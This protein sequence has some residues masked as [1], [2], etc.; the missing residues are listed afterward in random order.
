LLRRYAHG[1]GVD[2][3]IVWYEGAGLSVRNYLIADHLGS[4]IAANGA[5]TTRYAYGPYG[6][7]DAWTGSRFRYTGQAALPEVQ[8][9]HYKAR[10]YDP[11]L[12]RFLQTDPVGYE[13]DLNL[14]AYVRNDPLSLSDPSG[15]G[16]ASV[17]VE[18]EAIQGAY[19]GGQGAGVRV[20]VYDDPDERPTIEFGA[21]K[22]GRYGVGVDRGATVGGQYTGG[23]SDDCFGNSVNSRSRRKDQECVAR[24]SDKLAGSK[25]SWQLKCGRARELD[26][27]RHGNFWEQRTWGP[28]VLGVFCAA[29]VLLLALLFR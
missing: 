20:T 18:G 16:S 11:V 21:F 3:P 27:N 7:P 6:E 9:Y 29:V 17:H 19:G 26:M 12:G 24:G 10:V 22:T 23:D 25:P 15:K 2:E 8:L 28:F 13:D 4:I 14:Y 5:S 1:P